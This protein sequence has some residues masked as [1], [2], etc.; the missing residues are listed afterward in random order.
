MAR[1]RIAYAQRLG[2]LLD[3]TQ[4]TIERINNNNCFFQIKVGVENCG[5]IDPYL[6]C[7]R[8][9]EQYVSNSDC[10]ESHICCKCQQICI[11]FLKNKF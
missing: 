10:D 11:K 4:K 3:S 8:Y 1:K 5:P 7:F 2:K 6:N 9:D